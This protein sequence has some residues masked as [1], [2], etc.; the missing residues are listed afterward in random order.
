[1]SL[2][3][4]LRVACAGML[5]AASLATAAPAQ[6]DQADPCDRKLERLEQ[7]FREIEARRGYDAA[8]R[9]WNEHGWPTYYERCLAP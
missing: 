6:A 9:W 5:A 8:A 7:R 1:M 4:S 3:R 2:T